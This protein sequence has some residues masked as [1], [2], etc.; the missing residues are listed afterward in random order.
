MARARREW[1][2][3]L[4]D[5]RLML[6]EST[7]ATSYWTDPQ[8]LLLF[9]NQMDMRALQLQ[10]AVEGY[11]TTSTTSNI[12][13]GTASYALP[14]GTGRPRRV[15]LRRTFGS[16]T[17][18]IPL[19][20]DE[21]WDRPVYNAASGADYNYA[22]PTYKL[23]GANVVLSPTPT[24]S[25]TNG[26]VVEYECL[27]DRLVNTTDK[28]SLAFPDIT[29]TLLIYDTVVAAFD[30]EASQN[31]LAPEYTAGIRLFHATLTSQWEQYIELR[32]QGSPVRGTPFYL[33][34]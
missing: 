12:V 10:N 23:H 21:K 29:E 26:L 20:R 13:S 4:A 11:F 22:V 34:D 33:G 16:D 8:L 18:D 9:N 31:D 1:S 24:S 17:Q 19:T 32:T 2:S 28:I 6:R 15:L 5:I 25:I 27:P 14:E 3:I 7:A 30:M